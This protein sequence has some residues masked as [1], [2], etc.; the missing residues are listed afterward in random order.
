LESVRENNGRVYGLDSLLASMIAHVWYPVNYFRLSF[1]KQ[2]QLGKITLLL[3]ETS[4]LDVDS[5][6]SRVKQ[7]AIEHLQQR[8]HVGR[9]IYFLGKFV[10]YRFLRPFFAQTL[11]G[12]RDWEVNRLI[13]Q[14][15]DQA[16]YNPKP[17]LYRFV[18][19]PQLAIEIHPEWLSYLQ[20]HLTILTGF[21]LWHLK[22]SA[23]KQC[24]CTKHCRK[25]VRASGTQP[26]AGAGILEFCAC[27]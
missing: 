11:R 17:C 1:G 2:D 16:F 15:A 23:E 9:E 25:I 6:S 3:R 13:R 21:C 24:K 4:N 14:L 10:P 5:P 27:S 7:V 22:L 12:A 19:T 26:A 20:Q 8:D 18:E